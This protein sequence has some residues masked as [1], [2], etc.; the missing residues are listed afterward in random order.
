MV[1]YRKYPLV[2][3]HIR[4]GRCLGL[5]VCELL[6]LFLKYSELFLKYSE[7]FLKYSEL[8]AKYAQW[9]VEYVELFRT[10][11]RVIC[12][13]IRAIYKIP[14]MMSKIL[15]AIYQVQRT[16]CKMRGLLNYC[17]NQRA[18]GCMILLISK[19]CSYKSQVKVPFTKWTC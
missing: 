12:K 15:R 13:P 19:Q 2:N 10:K 18:K 1:I 8:F 3:F 4:L 5:F 16:V 6:E 17:E 9:F 11:T 7:L 14:A